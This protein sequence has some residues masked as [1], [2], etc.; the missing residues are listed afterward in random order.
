[1][2]KDDLGSQLRNLFSEDPPEQEDEPVLGDTGAGVPDSSPE[3]AQAR[4]DT[5]DIP[6]EVLE[7][8][9]E[10]VDDPMTPPIVDEPR[11]GNERSA[12]TPYL[13][14][15]DPVSEV[16]A[17]LSPSHPYVSFDDP[18]SQYRLRP[19]QLID[20]RYKVLEPLGSGSYAEVYKCQ[21]VHLEQRF[22]VKLMSLP[23]ATED[24][25]REA[26]IAAR[27][28]HPSV[29]RVV[30]IG[31]LNDAGTWY[32][33]M[34][35]RE[36]SQ[37]LERLLD[38]AANNLRRLPLNERTLQVVSDVAQALEHAHDRGVIHRDVKPSNI[39]V[40]A[41]GHAYL[42]DFGL[43]MTK[44]PM[45]TAASMKTLGAQSGMSG[46][47]P[48]MAPEEFEEREESRHI[49][50]SA[51]VY[52]LAVVTY[53]M[54]VGQLPYPGKAAGPIIRQ[55]VEGIRTPPRQLNAEIPREVEAVLLRSLSVEPADRCGTASEFAQALRQSA[56]AYITDQ[57]LYEE[58]R[59]LFEDRQW[60]AALSHFEGLEKLAPG[61][62][63]TRLY[64]ERARKQVQLLDLYDEAAAMLQEGDFES[65]LDKLDVLVRLDP[66]FEVTEVR[67]K[68]REALVTRLYE[69][70]NEHYRAGR[71]AECLSVFD[72][73]W[74]RAP[75][76]RDE[77]DI[78]DRARRSHE[79]ER[80][81]QRLYDRSVESV[82]KE[83]WSAAQQALEELYREAPDYADVEA[84]LTMVRY[85][86]RLSMTF[87][88]AQECFASEDYDQ[89]IE[90]LDELT[91]MNNEYK[92]D[93]IAR[94]RELAADAL[95]E[96]AEHLLQEEE[97]E[98][99]S[100]AVDAFEHHTGRRDPN[101]IRARIAEGIAVREVC[102]KVKALY[103]GAMGFLKSDQL[104]ECLRV[105]AEIREVDPEFD[106]V[107]Y[108]EQRARGRLCNQYYAEALDA[109]MSRRHR[110]AWELWT[111]LREI[112]PEY[113]DPQ[114]LEARI[115]KR[116]N[117]WGWLAFWKKIDL[118]RLL[119]PIKARLPRRER[120]REQSGTRRV[121]TG[122]AIGL[123]LVAL[124]VVVWF[125]GRRYLAAALGPGMSAGV[126]VTATA[127]ETTVA[128]A[129]TSTATAIVAGAASQTEGTPAAAETPT[130]QPTATETATA[131][132]T[133]T[134]TVVPSPTPTQTPTSTP[135]PTATSVPSATPEPTA[136]ATATAT[137]TP[138]PTAV[139]TPLAAAVQ[140][141]SLFTAPSASSAE[142]DVVGEGETVEVLGRSDANY[143]TWIYARTAE[144]VEGYLWAPRFVYALKW[145]DLPVIAVTPTPVPTPT[146]VC[147]SGLTVAPGALKIVHVWP[148]AV[149][150]DSGWMAYVEVKIAG[151][152]GCNYFLYWDG[153][154]VEYVVKASEPDVAVIVRPGG[155]MLVGTVSVESDGKR[156][157][158][159]T[160]MAAPKCR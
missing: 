47:I 130:P 107:H 20:G 4:Y 11:N 45:G 12:V 155:G 54:L 30:N 113:S 119:G 10:P 134:Y 38:N 87:K 18:I 24:V 29:L 41:E 34:D 66:A 98:R 95:Y 144:G 157:S 21:D 42:T 105:V 7:A 13:G 131:A 72:E 120:D 40:D 14:T 126:T 149:C 51:D 141:A 5:E 26:R 158:Q 83:D 16:I 159:D 9:P 61:Y 93:Q 82:Q 65:C 46:T 92:A 118:D 132:P 108:V 153:E 151:G 138:G 103:N 67:D 56:Q 50:P 32:I 25:L 39:I 74:S 35:Y 117:R 99:A 68:A 57:E 62:R 133:A 80:Y 15:A 70:A 43:A 73:I 135:S 128:P 63:E 84:R 17:P 143:G 22:A 85:I 60:R 23:T 111:R 145:D 69:Q 115:L 121:I 160:S 129:A 52:S 81:L 89:C 152:D 71:Y 33:V 53:E 146:P 78:A 55:I 19:D 79:R 114:D 31:R 116:L 147:S 122:L 8:G 106:D 110:E 2:G 97:Y 86:A 109:L 27:I 96:Q 150:G 37:T 142:L 28:H 58:A 100:K 137:P 1:M 140:S 123:A 76:F 102:S 94:L 59:R 125:V 75:E 124:V 77:Q 3:S 88:L 127:T 6:S 44:R 136:T 91:Q 156:V 49:G 90:R 104:E 154:Q 64:V 112:D 139:P 48:Y 101:R 36:G 148:S